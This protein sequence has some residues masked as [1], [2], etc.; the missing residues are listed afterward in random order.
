MNSRQHSQLPKN[1]LQNLLCVAVCLAMLPCSYTFTFAAQ[2]ENDQ[3][4]VDQVKP[5]E[6]ETRQQAAQLVRQLANPDFELRQQASRELWKIGP[7][8]L[9]LLEAA[10][11]GGLNSEARLRARDLTTLI[12]V[13]LEHDADAEVVRCVVG[14]LDRE[15]VVQDLS[16]I[17]I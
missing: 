11:E 3:P 4:P 15:S 1:W 12:K 13:G 8:A 2:Q 5:L 9:K 6:G 10:V 17:H 7:P 14:F 16:L